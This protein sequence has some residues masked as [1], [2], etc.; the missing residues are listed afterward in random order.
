M[1]DRRERETETEFNNFCPYRLAACKKCLRLDCCNSCPSLPCHWIA[2]LFQLVDFLAPATAIAQMAQ[3]SLM[4]SSSQELP[5]QAWLDKVASDSQV[6]TRQAQ[7]DKVVEMFG[8]EEITAWEA[9]NPWTLFPKPDPR[10]GSNNEFRWKC[11]EWKDTLKAGGLVDQRPDPEYHG[12]PCPDPI[13]PG[14][15]EHKCITGSYICWNMLPKSEHYPCRRSKQ[16]CWNCHHPSHF[17]ADVRELPPGRRGLKG[18]RKLEHQE[19]L[20]AE[21]RTPWDTVD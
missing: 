18:T 12:P 2:I 15:Y 7:L 4:A 13:A 14:V 20:K 8:Q 19:R 1:Q 11:K 16:E 3:P 5:S 10:Q 17:R 21:G 9:A 6:V